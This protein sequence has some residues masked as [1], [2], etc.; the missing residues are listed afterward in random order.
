MRGFI[1]CCFFVFSAHLSSFAQSASDTT[2]QEIAPVDIKS[3]FSSQPLLGL[4][5]SAKVISKR[6][7]ESQQPNSLLPA[8][9][10][11]PGVRMEERSPGSYRIAMRGSMLR[12]PF[13]VRNTKIY[14][15]EIPFTDAGGNTYFNLID[16]IGVQSISI[17]KGP[18]GSLFG[19]NSGGVIRI[20]PNG[21]DPAPDA[22]SLLLG[23][24]SFANFNQ[25][26]HVQRELSDSYQFSFDQAYM[27]SDGF[28]ENTALDKK[29]FQTA[30]QWKY[31]GKGSLRLFALYSDLYYQTP[32]GL[33]EAQFADNPRQARPAT[34]TIPGAV[35]QQASITNRTAI[36]GITHQYDFSEKWTHS[37]TLFG[38]TTDFT[39]P[40]IT[41]YEKRDE[42]NYGLRSFVSYTNN[43]RADVQWQMQLGLEAQK[44]RYQINNYDNDGGVEADPQSF[45]LLWNGQHF[46]FYRAMAT[47]W[48][49]WN[50]EGS[51]GLNFND[52]AFEQQYPVVVN[53]MGNLS[54]DRA[55]LPRLAMSYLLHPQVAW[56]AS[57]SKGYSVPT[58]SEVRSSDNQINLDLKPESGISYETGFRAE[59]H[60][61]RLIADLSVYSYRLRDG[62]VRQLNEAGQE[63]FYNAGEIQQTGVEV[64]LMGQV[65]ASN[66]E[67]F[68]RSLN[69][70]TNLTYQDYT[71]K[72]Y[73]TVANDQSVDYRG[74]RVTSIPDWI[75]VNSLMAEFPCRVGI[76]IMHNY[77]SDIPLDDANTTFANKYNLIQAKVHWNKRVHPKWNVQVFFGVDNLLDE[78]Y[79]L[80]NDINA[81][82]GRFFNMAP[83]RNYY[84]GV[85]VGYRGSPA[86]FSK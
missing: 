27:R 25:Q 68:V 33:T 81:F 22:V 48:D 12:S 47:L 85:K 54:F 24:G 78:V 67:K 2:I 13:G 19:P 31:N 18:D 40:F 9:N 45:D 62:I 52:I 10:A 8:I 29:Y 66:T 79:S 3:Y 20:S 21:F 16:P 55:W 35:E 59:T 32:G 15:D 50:I 17:L 63:S 41:N 74:N 73:V 39:N 42:R 57:V 5:S 26:L 71:F 86:N 72:R 43:D 84:G 37:L 83:S 58:I 75:V 1:F 82:G 7:I 61:R 49:R 11:T 70:S 34:P 44:G 6:M 56:R 38:S 60:N 53:P 65:V 46:Y 76:N 14:I 80:G 4:T 64:L 36:G 23:G 69:L 51:V 77:T 28:R 30:H